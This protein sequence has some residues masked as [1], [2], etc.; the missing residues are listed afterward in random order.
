MSAR[1]YSVFL[2]L[3]PV[4]LK[5]K[6]GPE[7]T[8]VFLEDLEDSSRTR[9]FSGA[10]AVWYRSLKEVFRVA[11]PARAAQREV[12]VA[13]VMYVL[14]QIYMGAIV[15]LAPRGPSDPITSIPCG[16][17]IALTLVFPLFP[18]LIAFLALRVGNRAV[19]EPLCLVGK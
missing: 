11:L 3:Y 7:M 9:G 16:P 1:V 6:F 17:L 19:P 14:Q 18:A 5:E 2:S 13:L 10:A 8:R 12:A 15:L 4:E